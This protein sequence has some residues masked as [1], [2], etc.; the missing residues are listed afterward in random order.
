MNKRTQKSQHTRDSWEKKKTRKIRLQTARRR[1][2]HVKQRR[3]IEP[4]APTRRARPSKIKQTR[5]IKDHQSRQYNRMILSL[6]CTPTRPGCIH[7]RV[8]TGQAIPYTY[9]QMS[10]SRWSFVDVPLI[11][12]CPADHVQYS[13]GLATT[14]S[15]LLGTVWFRPDRLMLY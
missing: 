7:R 3:Y 2:W 4:I 6:P 15:I 14:Y 1:R 12:S 11:F 9:L 10:C 8:C 13:T 5:R